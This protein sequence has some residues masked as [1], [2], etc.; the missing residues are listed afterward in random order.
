MGLLAVAAVAVA[1]TGCGGGGGDF[2]SPKATFETMRAAAEA[3]NKEAFLACFDEATRKGIAELEKL[4]K[5]MAK[6]SP[7]ATEGAEKGADEF[8]AKMKGSKFEYGE[9]KIDGD[10]A[11]MDVTMDGDTETVKFAKAGG[12]WKISIPEIQGMVE[13]MK[14]MSQ[15]MK[16]MG[17][18]MEKGMEGMGEA[19][20]KGMQDAMEKAMP[21]EEK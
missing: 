3:G 20:K 16:G 6:K 2:S 19:M 10:K 8:M 1:L 15:M 7:K 21:K 12:Q 13:M 4:G 11:T 5:E 17:K 9:V 18:Q 14:G